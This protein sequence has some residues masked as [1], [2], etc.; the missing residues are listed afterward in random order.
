MLARLLET[1]REFLD[2]AR[3]VADQ[4]IQVASE[5]RKRHGARDGHKQPLSR[6]HQRVRHEHR[7][8]LG[9]GGPL[10]RADRVER[11]DHADDRAEKSQH[12]ADGRQDAQ[13]LVPPVEFV[14]LAGP[15]FLDRGSQLRTAINSTESVP[16]LID[17]IAGFF[18]SPER[19]M[20]T[21]EPSPAVV[22]Q[23]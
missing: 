15:G 22:L 17:L 16:A 4:V 3:Y 6:A 11:P 13:A 21:P 14:R 19:P 23:S 2:I 5:Q 7:K 12:R 10:Q 8:L 18:R 9:S 1:A 20:E